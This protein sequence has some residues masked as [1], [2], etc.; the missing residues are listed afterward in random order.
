MT[1]AASITA[2]CAVA[3]RQSGVPDVMSSQSTKP[4]IAAG[5]VAIKPTMSASHQA[6]AV[7]CSLIPSLDTTAIAAETVYAPIATSVRGG[8][9]GWPATPLSKNFI[10]YLLAS[11]PSSK[12]QL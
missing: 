5:A 12:V 4:V 10:A 3:V 7:L 1:V 8:W 9:R 11:T 6:V 2:R